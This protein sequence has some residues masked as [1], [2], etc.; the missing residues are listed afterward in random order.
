MDL[1]EARKIIGAQEPGDYVLDTAAHRDLYKDRVPLLS[2][3]LERSG[4]SAFA[5]AYAQKD[6]DAI[7][8]AKSY[9]NWMRIANLGAFFTSVFSAGGMALFLI[10][11]EGYR[12]FC[13]DENE[14]FSVFILEG[15]DN[16]VAIVDSVSKRYSAC[17]ARV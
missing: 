12:E 15:L 17:G 10:A 5:T 16:H 2:Q 11:D 6:K 14:F 3:I 4:V 9:R 7:K 13:Y 8:A 1:S